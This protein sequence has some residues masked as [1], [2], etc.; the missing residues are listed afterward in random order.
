MVRT[1]LF[2]VYKCS[3][4]AVKLIKLEGII[5]IQHETLGYFGGMHLKKG[6][7]LSKMIGKCNI[8]LIKTW[9]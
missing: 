6:K 9:C 3:K 7:L 2:M 5:Q 8:S 1:H 4:L